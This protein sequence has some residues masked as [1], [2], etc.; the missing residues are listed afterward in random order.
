MKLRS[1]TKIKQCL[2]EINRAKT[3]SNLL[4]EENISCK[5][6]N[7]TKK[8][9]ADDMKYTNTKNK[10]QTPNIS[11]HLDKTQC[12]D[13]FIKQFDDNDLQLYIDNTI[14]IPCNALYLDGLK[15]EIIRHSEDTQSICHELCLD[16]YNYVICMVSNSKLIGDFNDSGTHWSLLFYDNSDRKLYHLDSMNGY[17]LGCATEVAKKISMYINNDNVP[18]VIQMNC[19]QQDNGRD[20]G[21]Y[22]IRNL[23][24]LSILINCKIATNNDSSYMNDFDVKQ[25]RHTTSILKEY[26]TSNITH[27]ANNFKSVETVIG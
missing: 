11:H 25:I 16:Y 7:S 18:I 9:I 12:E 15:T 5:K 27:M 24:I 26:I 17:N 14:T 10:K 22:A 3:N 19:K 6:E 1:S 21:I 23:E 2:E 20:C 8:K 13:Y 4:N